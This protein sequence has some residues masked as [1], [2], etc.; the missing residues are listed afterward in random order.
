[1]TTKEIQDAIIKNYGNHPFTF[2]PNV[3]QMDSR[4]QYYSQ[5]T[6]KGFYFTPEEVVFSF[7]ENTSPSHFR[8]GDATNTDQASRGMALTLR[9]LDANPDVRIEGQSEGSGKVNYLKGNDPAKWIRNLSIY[10]KIVY[11]DLWSGIDLVFKGKNG[12]LKYE[13]VVQP[14]ANIK[15]IRLTYRGADGLSLD[16]EGNLQIETPYGVLIDERPISYQE[17][18]GQ[19]IAVPSSFKLK[20][21]K[22]GKNCYGFKVENGYDSCYPLIMD[23][24]LVYSTYLGGMSDDS[25]VGIA[26]DTE[27]NAYVT[28][29]T[30]SLDFPTSPGAFQTTSD[31]FQDAFVTKL[32][33]TGSALVYSTFLGG[34]QNSDQ[35]ISIAVDAAGNAYV[36]G[37]TLS[38]DFPTTPGAFDTTFKGGSLGQDAFVTKLNSTGSALLYST[39]LS[40]TEDD[41]GIDIVVDAAGNAYVTGN[42]TSMDFQTT[43]GAF[44]TVHNGGFYDAFVTK[45]NP[46]G[47]ALVYSTY[48]GGT[49]F[50]QATGIAVDAAGNA[51]V[52]GFTDSMD[53]QTTSGAFDTTYNGD[54]FDAFVT[55]LNPTGSALVYSTYLGGELSDQ[56][57]GISVDAAGNAYVTGLTT[58]RDFPTTQGA[59]DTTYNGGPF[60]AFVTKLNP[61]G[62]ALVYSTYLGGSSDDQGTDIFVDAEGNAYVTG[63]TQSPDFPTTSGAFDTTFNGGSDAFV[64]KLNSTG[65]APLLYSTY[66]GGNTGEQAFAIAV[67][68]AGNA[69]VTGFTISEDY[70]T[71]SGAFDTSYNGFSDAFVA[72]I[73]TVPSTTPMPIANVSPTSINFGNQPV[74]TSSSSQTVTVT[75][76]GTADLIINNV[77]IAG[78]NPTDFQVVSNMCTIVNP[79]NSCTIQVTFNPT[80]PGTRSATLN[81]FDNVSD[82]PQQVL[83]NGNGL[84]SADLMITKNAFVV[85]AGRNRKQITYTIT[86]L[87]MGPNTA[88]NVVVTDRLQSNTDFVSAT[89]SQGTFTAPRRGRSGTVTFTLGNISAGSSANMTI[90]VTAKANAFVTNT[91]TVSSS[92]FDPGPH[93]NSASVIIDSTAGNLNDTGSDESSGDHH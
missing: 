7:I 36:T 85:P 31:G 19:Q 21:Q 56:G 64:T 57:N 69:Y 46:A 65:S 29:V 43:S 51:Y 83:L 80:T 60:D 48:L 11:R 77:M 35:G 6:G 9:F 17:I 71:T 76:T 50:D 93:P 30:S 4:V 70:P 92:T 16:D 78:E 14:G 91:A 54:P 1:M 88:S 41:E 32:N 10:E 22:Q 82:S 84:P 89:T 47:S 42:T 55:K 18:N 26:V 24:G 23:P 52:T 40:G 37:F 62:S 28:G 79:G 2:V 39:F 8:N 38:A 59:F 34:T 45:L 66:L 44:D 72:K 33:P 81:I 53:F 86:V 12:Q 27:G 61:T 75:N 90:V 74:N 20:K 67:D 3:G 13:F 5:G 49:G 15:D 25:G 58:S 87:N 68:A 73:S 63:F